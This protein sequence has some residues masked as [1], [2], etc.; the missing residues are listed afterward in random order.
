MIRTLSDS[1]TE[2]ERFVTGAKSVQMA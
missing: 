1:R 2:P